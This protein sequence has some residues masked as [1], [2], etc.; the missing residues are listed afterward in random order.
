MK[1]SHAKGS[2]NQSTYRGCIRC[3]SPTSGVWLSHR[4][5]SLQCPTETPKTPSRYDTSTRVCTSL[6]DG[7]RG[8]RHEWCESHLFEVSIRIYLHISLTDKKHAT[9]VVP[10]TY[11]PPESRRS[12][13]SCTQ[14]DRSLL[15]V[16]TFALH[17]DMTKIHNN[18]HNVREERYI[19]L[20][21]ST[22]R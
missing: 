18:K 13:P 3:R 11:C 20:E 12:I 16:S 5:G 2:A 21:D 1:R 6:L 10:S 4:D 22:Y 17:N 7:G 19:L 9:P 15:L 14:S 8:C